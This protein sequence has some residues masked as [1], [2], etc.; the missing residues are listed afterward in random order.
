MKKYYRIVKIDRNN[1]TEKVFED[2]LNK[3]IY[4]GYDYDSTYRTAR[5][6]YFVFDHITTK[7]HETIKTWM[8]EDVNLSK[9]LGVKDENK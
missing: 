5:H 3:M 8:E 7:S 6:I 9:L 4:E 2:M 1:L